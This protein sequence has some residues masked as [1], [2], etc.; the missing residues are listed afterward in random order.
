MRIHAYHAENFK[1]L[2]RVDIPDPDET[3]VIITGKNAQ[4]KSSVLDGIWGALGGASASPEQAVR[5][6]EKRA[7]VT[8]DL[9][10]IVVTRRWQAGGNSTVVVE[11]RDGS[12]RKSP[13]TLLDS[14]V[15]KVAFDPLAFT[16]WD[17]AKQAKVLRQLAGLDEAFAAI[18]EQA[19]A[20]Y[21]E[22]AAVNRA[23]KQ[24][25]ALLASTGLAGAFA[26]VPD[27]EQSAADLAAE[28]QDAVNEKSQNDAIRQDVKRLRGA[29]KDATDGLTAAQERVAALERDLEAARDN[30]RRC[31]AEVQDATHEL[32]DTEEFAASL[33]DPDLQAL[34][35]RLNSIEAF[36]R[37][38]RAKQERKA[39]EDRLEANRAEAQALTG[40]MES[41]DAEKAA[42]LATADF[43]VDGLGM[44]GETVTLGGVPLAQ[45]ST[46]QQI[47]LGLAVGA[48]LNPKLRVAVVRDGSLLD[49]TS[50]AAVK[51]WAEEH[52]VQVWLE[53]VGS[54]E[55]RTGVIIEDGAVYA[56]RR[57]GG[58]LGAKPGS[59]GTAADLWT[60]T[61]KQAEQLF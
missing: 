59:P 43:P 7:S 52:D 47:R 54:A 45:A 23:V 49:D 35:D 28:Y 6:G 16:R 38:V 57:E 53:R 36:N 21:E 25:E 50:L 4:G 32:V 37:R 27:Q 12:Q 5:R 56:D 24:D 30:E 22:R 2:K 61:M 51:V 19:R 39:L 29:K 18:D 14:L 17:G 8:L 9:G 34:K 60:D 46:A 15:G 26:D 55:S 40:R 42:R 58:D 33:I 11:N 41:L 10:E 13:Q 48:A 44:T 1:G 31:R 20:A 3:L